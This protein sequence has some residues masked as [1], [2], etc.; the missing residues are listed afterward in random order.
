MRK[1]AVAAEITKLVENSYRDVNIAFA[2]ELSLVCDRMDVDPWEVIE[3]ANRHPRVNILSPGP[4]V[5]GHCISVDPWFLVYA[6]PE[7]TRL[8]R[9]ARVVNDAKPAHVVEHIVQLASQFASPKIGCLGLA[10][11]ANV[12]DLR[13]SPSLEIVRMLIQRNVGQVMACDPH[14]PPGR[15]TEF[16]LHGLPAVLDQCQVLALLTDHRQFRDVPRRVL[17]EKVVVDTRGMWR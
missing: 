15:F 8:I 2:N 10:Y 12:D 13:E 1:S 3:L 17:Q 14:V 16:P 4:G 5:G 9:T 7:T 6:D 11:K